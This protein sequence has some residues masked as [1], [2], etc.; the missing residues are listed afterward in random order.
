MVERI[1]LAQ[2]P[3][4][5]EPLDRLSEAWGGPRIWAKRDDLTG[6]GLSG[7]KV[8]KIEFHA[9]A[10][11]AARATTL[12]TTGAEQS[13]H[14]RATALAAAKIGL[15][16]ELFLRTKD[17]AP[18]D[19]AK[20][21]HLLHRLSGAAIHFITPDEYRLRDDLMAERKAEL[22][23]AGTTAWV[24]PEGASDYLGML[25]FAVAGAEL[26]QQIETW[27]T[28]PP[29]WHASSSGGTTAG[30]ALSAAEAGH[31]FAVF[32]TSVGDTV[33]ELN[34]RLA[35]IWKETTQH[36]TIPPNLV[37]PQLTDAYVGGGY[38]LVDEAELEC[39]LEATRL[40][41]LLF[42]PVYTGKAI[43]GL[44]EEI[45][46]GGFDGVTDVIFWHTGGG[47]GVFAHDFG[48]DNES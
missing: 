25:G 44:R 15:G 34:G 2:L 47:F 45:R 6:F 14:C 8:R 7:N 43:Y 28:Q 24:I 37:A 22:A 5:L 3:T 13:N 38:A 40:T 23:A 30:L 10:A 31:C 39:Q 9:A 32:G 18:P 42:D 1:P 41:G 26:A 21:N 36:R 4:P 46:A 20:G 11:V 16:C 12:I 17:G 33:A 29:V 19:S 27:Q 48:F 35:A